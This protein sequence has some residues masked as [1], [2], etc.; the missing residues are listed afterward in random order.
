MR[1]VF[2]ILFA[3]AV[4]SAFG[5][6]GQAGD[7]ALIL[8]VFTEGCEATCEGFKDAIAKSG[9]PAEVVI[10]DFAQDQSALSQIVQEARAVK[11]DLVLTVGTSATLGIIGSLEDRG[12]RRFLQKIPAVFALVED[13]FGSRIAVGLK[14]SGRANVAG[15]FDR[16]PHE[17]RIEAIRQF[18]PGFDRLGLLYNANEPDAVIMLQ[19][20]NQLTSSLGIELVALDI[21]PGTSAPPN[22]ALIPLRLAEMAEM[23]VKWVTLGAGSFLQAHGALLT[24]SAVENG[25]AI[26]SPYESLVREQQALLSIAARRSDVG[27]RAA[28]QALKILRDGMSPGDLPIVQAR[29]F[30]YLVN[31]DVVARLDRFPPSD[32]FALA[33]TQGD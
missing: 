6:A 28:E 16:V 20:L 24:A 17:A 11:A 32:F 13:P 14:G 7:K 31:M 29:D 12:D 3:A 4:L 21:E 25:I 26:V 2:T 1:Q 15:S 10:R 19:E 8:G 33:E 23:G 9:F 30:A 18:D 22:P 5:A 27:K